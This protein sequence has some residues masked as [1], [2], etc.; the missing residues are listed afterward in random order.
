MS[1]VAKVP[2]YMSVQEFLVW[3]SGDY[4]RYELV[5]GEPRAM[6][7]TKTIHGFL[8]SEMCRLI[9]NHLRDGGT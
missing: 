1:V 9:G 7:P 3:E 5:D 4:L 2:D 6:A 8:Q